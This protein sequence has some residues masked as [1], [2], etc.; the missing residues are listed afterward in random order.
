MVRENLMNALRSVASWLTGSSGNT[1][2]SEVPEKL[3]ATDVCSVQAQKPQIGSY[4]PCPYVADKWDFILDSA[5][6]SI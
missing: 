2:N 6:F 4:Q 3:D 1:G 5:V